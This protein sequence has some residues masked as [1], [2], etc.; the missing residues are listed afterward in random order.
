MTVLN[1]KRGMRSKMAVLH[2]TRAMWAI[3]S[4]VALQAEFWYNIESFYKNLMIY[5]SMR[6]W[7]RNGGSTIVDK[8]LYF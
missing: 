7:K 6:V 3:K 5:K 4:I 8:L 1:R 2:K